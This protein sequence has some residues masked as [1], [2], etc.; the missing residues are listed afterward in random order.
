MQHLL[1]SLDSTI[2]KTGKRSIWLDGVAILVALYVLRRLMQSKK[3]PLHPPGPKPWPIL[4][5][6]L[7]MPSSKEWLTFEK[8]GEEYGKLVRDDHNALIN[9]WLGDISSIDV[10]GQR[11]VVL[12]DVET[13]F[14]MLQKK[15]NIYSDRP[16]LQMGGELVGW[17]DTLVLLRPCERFRFYRKGFHQTIGTPQLIREFLPL[18]EQIGQRLLQKF[19]ED[20][21]GLYKHIRWTYVGHYSIVYT[22]FSY[23]VE[24][25]P[26]S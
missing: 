14:N 16:T 2:W 10:F 15:D 24:R 17:K 8:W 1:T 11:I 21:T 18:E 5:N 13:A 6:A 22:A 19:A 25:A 12:N 23:F 4:G 3:R 20:P 9:S 7:D 26:S